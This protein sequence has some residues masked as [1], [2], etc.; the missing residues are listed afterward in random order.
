MPRPNF[1]KKKNDND[2][3]INLYSEEEISV[4]SVRKTQLIT[5]F[6]IGSIVD[7]KYSGNRKKKNI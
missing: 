2:G 7:F 6:G 4:G 1:K 5:T 3:G